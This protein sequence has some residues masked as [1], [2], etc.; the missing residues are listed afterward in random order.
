MNILQ[1]LNLNW[2]VSVLL[3][4]IK[5][6]IKLFFVFFCFF[7]FF[8]QILMSVLIFLVYVEM[9]FVLI[10]MDPI[11]VPALTASDSP[12]MERNV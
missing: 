2:H 3:L 6:V 11:N 8:L 10:L 1:I 7:F 5:H 4:Q 9:V 12:E